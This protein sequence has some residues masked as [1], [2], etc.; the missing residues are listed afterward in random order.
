MGTEPDRLLGSGWRFHGNDP[1]SGS[2]LAVMWLAEEKITEVVIGLPSA[3]EARGFALTCCSSRS[4]PR[5]S[6]SWFAADFR[7]ARLRER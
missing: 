7:A 4:F 2:I 1:G 6:A 5:C 3:A